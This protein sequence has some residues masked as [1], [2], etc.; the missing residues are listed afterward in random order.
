MGELRSLWNLCLAG[1][2]LIGVPGTAGFISKWYLITA[3]LNEGSTGVMLALIIIVSS[4]IAV[5]Y[6]WRVVE[7]A[8]FHAPSAQNELG[9]APMILLAATWIAALMNLYF[10]L[11]PSVPVELAASAGDLLMGHLQ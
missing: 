11:N 1:L 9:E 4:L 8:Y 6:I 3:V 7:A 10:G 2:S 5:V